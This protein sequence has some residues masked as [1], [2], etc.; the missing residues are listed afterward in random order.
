MGQKEIKGVGELKYFCHLLLGGKLRPFQMLLE[1]VIYNKQIL[2]NNIN[3]L[4][5]IR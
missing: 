3:T 4:F 5:N 1:F 2:I